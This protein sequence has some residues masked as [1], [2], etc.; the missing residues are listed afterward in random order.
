VFA[1]LVPEPT[2]E[3]AAIGELLAASREQ[4]VAREEALAAA[5]DDLTRVR[6]RAVDWSLPARGWSIIRPGLRTSYSD[7]RAAMRAAFAEP[8]PTAFHG[9]RKRVKDLWY[10]TLLLQNVWKGVQS[11]CADTLEKL[12]DTLGEDHDLEVLREALAAYPALDP[13]ARH[14]L[15]ARADARSC[16][17]RMTAW[18]AGQRLYAESPRR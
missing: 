12:S 1:R 3:L 6:A 14:E 5:A 16:E 15:L 10:H 9:W 2:P 8:S 17:L 4:L 7:G 11:A 18:T 13:E